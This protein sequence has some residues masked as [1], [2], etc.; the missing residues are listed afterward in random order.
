MIS[1]RKV[2]LWVFGLWNKLGEDGKEE[3]V[4][5]WWNRGVKV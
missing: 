3:Y 1:Y 4:E 2:V 5:A